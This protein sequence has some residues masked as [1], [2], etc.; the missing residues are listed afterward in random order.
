MSP[1]VDRVQGTVVTAPGR[2]DLVKGRFQRLAQ[3]VR[4]TSYRAG[5]VLMQGGR[6]R[7]RKP[8]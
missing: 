7:Q 4:I 8:G 2:P 1:I 5:Q 3:P 6:G